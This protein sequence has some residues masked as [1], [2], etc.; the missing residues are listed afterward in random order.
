MLHAEAF[1]IVK[2]R[3]ERAG[4]QVSHDKSVAAV[5]QSPA[6]RRLE[7]HVLTL[8]GIKKERC[9][10]Q[11]SGFTRSRQEERGP[12]MLQ[13]RDR[14]EQSSTAEHYNIQKKAGTKT[15]K[16]VATSGAMVNTKHGMKTGSMTP[17]RSGGRKRTPELVL[18]LVG[19]NHR[20]D[21]EQMWMS[22]TASTVL[23]MLRR[24]GHL[25]RLKATAVR[26]RSRSTRTGGKQP[27]TRFH[28]T[29]EEFAETSNAQ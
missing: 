3:D 9:K 22:E 4:T 23:Q 5:T 16:H 8:L 19:I 24:S 2:D 11:A 15:V 20:M 17:T 21:P 1:R 25:Q 14:P 26:S 18:T 29:R 10:R 27:Q 13:E 28:G 12:R 6:E 7:K